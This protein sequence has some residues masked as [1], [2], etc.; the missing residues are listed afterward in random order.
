MGQNNNPLPDGWVHS[1]VAEIY[2]IVG[3]GTPSTSV[4]EFWQGTIPW[5]T[6]ADI[7]GLKDIRPRKQVSEEAVRSSA[8]NVVPKDSLIVVTRVGLGKVGLADTQMCFSQDSHALVNRGAKPDTLYALYYLSQAV[9]VFKHENRG[10]TIAGVTKKQLAT[11][12]FPL[13]PLAEQHRIVAAIEEHLTRLDAGV[14]ALKRAQAKLRRYKAA[15][16]K[17]ACEGRLVPQDPSDEP[18][19]VLL[20]R[21]LAERRARWEADELAKLR[22]KGKEPLGDAWKLK[23]EEPRGPDTLA[24]PALPEGWVWTTLPQLGELA[25]GKS[26]HR[27][28]DDARLYGGPYPFVQTGEVK[29]SNGT[30]ST[31]TQTYSE[32]GLAQ[33]RL[34]PK[35]T[36]CITIAANIADTGILNFEACFP[37]SVVGFIGRETDSNV[38]FVEYFLR[39]AKDNLERYAPATA[40]K[41]I[42][43]ETLNA[44]G[45]PF[46]PLAEQER[47][48]AEVDRRLSI[49][50][51]VEAEIDANLA[52]ARALRQAVLAKAFAGAAQ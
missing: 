27:P 37:D 17:A 29:H 51:E 20:G 12:P 30:I 50:R 25:R 32:F 18:A 16:L 3:G 35:G 42:N 49:V 52:R 14:A 34:W 24:L 39:T 23:Y 21:I 28:R 38:R 19:D 11:L 47:I 10:T 22:A 43:L 8:T 44:L 2:D 45:I 5:I 41:N 26:K 31:Y 15:V 46:P 40:Q 9:S 36:L 4:P 6:S 33:S 13:P 7:Y 1:T 48:V